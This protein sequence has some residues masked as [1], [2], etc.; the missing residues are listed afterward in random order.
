MTNRLLPEEFAEFEVFARD[1]CLATEKERYDRRLSSTMV[2][3]EEFYDAFFPRLEDAIKYCDSF[4]LDDLPEDALHLLYLVYSLIM[5]SMSVEIF[6]QPK[7]V[8]SADA[9]LDRIGEPVP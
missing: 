4:P 1:W 7:A 8:D 2:E 3:M 9:V 6:H 5:V